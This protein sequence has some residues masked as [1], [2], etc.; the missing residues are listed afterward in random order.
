M[1][2]RY[3]PMAS[4]KRSVGCHVPVSGGLSRALAQGEERGCDAIQ[5]FPS[6]PRGWAVPSPDLAEEELLAQGVLERRWPLFLHSP[7]LVNIGAPDPAV[8]ERSIIN[9]GFSLERGVRLGA[10]GV[11]VHTGSAKGE[12]R[13]EAVA[14]A[15]ET[16]VD[17]LEAIPDS[18]ILIEITAGSGSL[19]AGTIDELADVFE[20]AEW[21]P[22]LG[23]C[24]DTCHLFAAGV[25]ISSETGRKKMRA[26]LKEIGPERVKVIHVND[27]RD[28][29]GSRRD[30]HARIGQGEIGEEPLQKI[31][32]WS[33]LKHAPLILETPGD[34]KENAED[35][36][37][38]RRLISSKSRAT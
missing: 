14:R 31:L 35:I 7:Y 28:P 10:V 22:R 13:D 19:I 16:V 3:L 23:I 15:G 29:L 18:N 4:T 36:A 11:V 5:A 2:V 8:H 6:N 34:A 33:E 25:D 20:A 17:L 30:R 9:L 21:H 26:S 27:S 32:A 38:V 1:P 37:I 24:L 12:S